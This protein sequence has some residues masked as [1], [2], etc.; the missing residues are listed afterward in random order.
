MSIVSHRRSWVEV[1]GRALRHNFRVL[2]GLL[3]RTTKLLAVVKANAYGHG[4]VPM[5]TELESIGA[6]WLGVANVAEGIV[7][8]EVGVRLPVLLL[9]ATLPG[10]MEEAERRGL[11]LTISTY[12][13]ARQL[14][15]VARALGRPSRSISRSTPAWAG[16]APGTQWR[17]RSWRT[18][19][20]CRTCASPGCSP[21]S[22]PP[23]TMPG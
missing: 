5:A 13:E 2:R 17:A 15:R 11:T 19:G 16:S 22:P 18:S 14:D 7:V 6:D 4:L 8:R 12:G 10:E 3:P 9:S 21:T 23:T 1:D 20:G